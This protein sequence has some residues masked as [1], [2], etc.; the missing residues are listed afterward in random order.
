ME[1]IALAL[2]LAVAAV[3][4][5]WAATNED[6]HINFS[7]FLYT[8][9]WHMKPYFRHSSWFVT[10]MHGSVWYVNFQWLWFGFQ[11]DNEW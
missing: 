1:L 7:L 6:G 2:L 11:L 8:R 10:S 5:R 3:T 4:W 9:N